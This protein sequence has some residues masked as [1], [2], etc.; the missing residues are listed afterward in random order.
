M[1]A[2]LVSY[3]GVLFDTRRSR[4]IHHGYR[5]VQSLALSNRVVLMTSGTEA[6][7]SHQMRTEG[8]L[9]SISDVID[10]SVDLPPMELWK[11]QMEVAVSR[12]AV[13]TVLSGDP[14]VVEWGSDHGL[15]SLL[16]V[17]PRHANPVVRLSNGGRKWSEVL[18]EL[19]ERG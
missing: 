4:G 5:L 10:V 9:S 1:S 6:S 18:D 14:D 7:V 19:I 11:R 8:L 16:Y 3:E 15:V 12:A 13:D 17:H 2:L